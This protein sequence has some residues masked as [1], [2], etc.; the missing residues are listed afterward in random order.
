M[1]SSLPLMTTFL[2]LLA[3]MTICSHLATFIFSPWAE[4]YLS[5]SS[6]MISREIATWSSVLQTVSPVTSSANY[7]DDSFISASA[8]VSDVSQV[9]C[10]LLSLAATLQKT[11]IQQTIVRIKI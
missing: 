2:V 11:T 9:K 10:W 5:Y 7:T 1:A 3:P 6:I 4:K 8:L